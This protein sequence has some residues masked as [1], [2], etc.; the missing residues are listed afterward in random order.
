MSPKASHE[1]AQVNKRKR[2][3]MFVA[4]A[5]LFVWIAVV[6]TASFMIVSELKRPKLEPIAELAQELGDASR[7]QVHEKLGQ[8]ERVILANAINE[9][10]PQELLLPGYDAL[11]MQA[12]SSLE[13][14][15][16][17]DVNVDLSSANYA[18]SEAVLVLYF[19]E[20]D[21]VFMVV[22]THP[23]PEYVE[24]YGG[25]GVPSPRKESNIYY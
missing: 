11:P 20:S 25:D 23:V 3:L 21:R 17:D 19:D 1:S 2:V 10:D 18:D 14:Y 5:L 22:I 8:P 12:F 15:R 4:F 13:V 7:S 9:L 16:I 24:K 6:V